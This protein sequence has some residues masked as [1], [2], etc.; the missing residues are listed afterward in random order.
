MK[1]NK[2]PREKSN[3]QSYRYNVQ[4]RHSGNSFS[5]IPWRLKCYKI[6]KNP[7]QI[8]ILTDPT[9]SK[10][11]GWIVGVASCLPLC[12]SAPIYRFGASWG[13]ILN[14]FLVWERFWQVEERE[15]TFY[16][17]SR[18][19]LRSSEPHSWSFP[20]TVT[21]TQISPEKIHSTS[22]GLPDEFRHFYSRTWTWKSN[23][24]NCTNNVK[25]PNVPIFEGMSSVPLCYKNELN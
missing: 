18:L 2:Y 25:W 13:I 24:C 9:S 1:H 10:E 15:T 6:L 8:G 14:Q 23:M 11:A 16:V 21:G 22:E 4:Q 20:R 7:L 3:E 5:F 17:V 19:L 12:K